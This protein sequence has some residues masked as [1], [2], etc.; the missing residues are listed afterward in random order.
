MR[1]LRQTCILMV[2]ALMPVLATAQTTPTPT[3]PIDSGARVRVF[4]P[5]TS[6]G[7]VT[8]KLIATT[9]DT[10]L[11]VAGRTA[12]ALTIATPTIIR[13][14][15]AQ[16]THT[17][18]AKFGILGGLLGTAIG[19]AWGSASY[20]PPHCTNCFDFGPEF[21]TTGGAVLGLLVGSVTGVLSGSKPTD[22]WV[23]VPLP[24]R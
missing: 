13:L 21:S 8:G 9:G 15:V 22:N 6:R 19:A 10:V 7:F 12:R 23:E 3:W 16:G 2:V 17:R 5:P 24:H 11:V 1:V 18:K 14:D 4:S 20:S